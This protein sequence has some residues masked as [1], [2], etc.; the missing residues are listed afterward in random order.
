MI[1]YIICSATAAAFAAVVF[2]VVAQ[3]RRHR[4]KQR[5]IAYAYD[6]LVRQ[7]KLAIEYSEFLCYRYIGLD[8]RNKK[9]LLIDH[10]GG[11]KQEQCISLCEIRESRIIHTSD[12]RGIQ[13]ILLELSHKWNNQPVQFCFYHKDHDPVMELP[14]LQR[15]AVHWKTKVDIHK[16]PGNMNLDVEYV[17]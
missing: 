11:Q 10:C 17:L 16:H 2:K 15:K 5:A 14:T 4:K 6:C 3:Q 7:Y 1:V 8:R 12:K 9:L 13:A